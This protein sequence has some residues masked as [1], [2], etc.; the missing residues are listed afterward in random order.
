MHPKITKRLKPAAKKHSNLSAL[1]DELIKRK[2]NRA[3]FE[4]SRGYEK[5]ASEDLQDVLR[6]D[7]DNIR[8]R[9]LLE[10]LNLGKEH[11]SKQTLRPV[12]PRPPHFHKK[13]SHIETL[14]KTIH[15][16]GSKPKQITK[17]T[18][19]VSD[20][21]KELIKRKL[22]RAQFEISRGYT[23]EA[24]KDIQDALRIDADNKKAKELLDSLNGT[25]QKTPSDRRAYNVEALKRKMAKSKIKKHPMAML[26][27]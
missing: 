13:P 22:N 26:N 10:S 17:K 5:E 15:P 20:L 24:G 16:T 2:L 8:A 19:R 6:L 3:Q 4:I 7:A 21:E 1:E 9:K 27:N 12:H 25:G 11:L 14:Q 18:S 23:E